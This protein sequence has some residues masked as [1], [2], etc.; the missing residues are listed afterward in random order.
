MVK[1]TINGHDYYFHLTREEVMQMIYDGTLADMN[2][3]I[4]TQ[5]IPKIVQLLKVIT[6]HAYGHIVG[7]CF[8]KNNYESKNFLESKDGREL[9]DRFFNEINFCQQFM[10]DVLKDNAEEF[11]K[12]ENKLAALKGSANKLSEKSEPK[13]KP[14]KKTKY[15]FHY[16]YYPEFVLDTEDTDDKN[17]YVLYVDDPKK[18]ISKD[19]VCRKNADITVM[20]YLNHYAYN[21]SMAEAYFPREKLEEFK[22]YIKNLDMSLNMMLGA[23]Y[24]EMKAFAKME[25]YVGVMQREADFDEAKR[26]I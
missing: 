1:A 6:E 7:E 14:K 8:V 3:I 22:T 5:D 18:D 11:I 13:P 24:E 2:T 17:Y 26:G 21:L 4:R 9:F 10:M 20:R 15:P 25:C 23:E 12:N 16:E 19:W